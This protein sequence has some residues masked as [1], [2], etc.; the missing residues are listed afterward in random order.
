MTGRLQYLYPR[1][2]LGV[3]DFRTPCRT[4]DLRLLRPVLPLSVSIILIQLLPRLP[5]DEFHNFAVLQLWLEPQVLL[6]GLRAYTNH[7]L[8]PIYF[9]DLHLFPLS[10][11]STRSLVLVL[12]R[13]AHQRCSEHTRLFN[14]PSI[15]LRGTPYRQGTKL[16]LF[17]IVKILTETS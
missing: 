9:Q 7:L 15:Y 12:L 1:R 5:E 3:Q 13:Q 11:V 10:R 17:K 4:G 6:H 16:Q 2:R 14:F 8:N